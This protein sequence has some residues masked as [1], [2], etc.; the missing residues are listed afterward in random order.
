MS[1]VDTWHHCTSPLSNIVRTESAAVNVQAP[2]A[3]NLRKQGMTTNNNSE[4]YFAKM[5]CGLLYLLINAVANIVAHTSVIQALRK[6][7]KSFEASAKSESDDFGGTL[8]I[9]FGL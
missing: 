2:N 1:H 3:G 7:S 8:S 4:N 6:T 5:A 9:P